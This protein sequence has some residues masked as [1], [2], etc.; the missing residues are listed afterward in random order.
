LRPW[1]D[2]R[3]DQFAPDFDGLTWFVAREG[4]LYAVDATAPD[5]RRL[6]KVA[7]DDASV[8]QIR[9]SASSLSV[10]F[11]SLMNLKLRSEVWTY[12][13]PGLVLRRRDGVLADGLSCVQRDK[14]G[15]GPSFDPLGIGADGAVG[16]WKRAEA[17]QSGPA[18]ETI[19][20]HGKIKVPGKAW[21]DLPIT[22]DYNRRSPYLS[23]KWVAAPD[24]RGDFARIQLLN[25]P[26]HHFHGN[27]P[28][29]RATIM[30]EMAKSAL[31][32]IQGERM[33]V[34]DQCGRLLV[35]CLKT[36]AVIRE[37]RIAG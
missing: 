15:I 8:L 30:L 24:V 12:E 7:E 14:T 19:R 4:A 25:M 10:H 23:E 16:G 18:G 31:V 26:G 17:D 32:R 6:W 3:F 27:A 2:A 35:L 22:A 1:R 29:V 36:G 34:F 28:A 33:L 21:A 13:L 37:H 9:R 11:Y 5:W 20:A